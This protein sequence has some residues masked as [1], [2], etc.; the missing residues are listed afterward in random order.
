MFMMMAFLLQLNFSLRFFHDLTLV[1]QDAQSYQPDTRCEEKILYQKCFS[2][3]QHHN[4]NK[5]AEDHALQYDKEGINIAFEN[6][7]KNNDRA[8]YAYS[9]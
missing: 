6:N 2:Q 1:L 8:E 3:Y 9:K 5:N 7:K 4:K